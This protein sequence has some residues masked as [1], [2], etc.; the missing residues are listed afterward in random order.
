MSSILDQLHQDHINHSKLLDL[1]DSD[2]RSMQDAGTT[3][4]NEML[5]IMEYMTKYPDR[6]H[7]PCEEIIFDRLKNKGDNEAAVIRRLCD[8]HERLSA[9][10]HELVDNLKEVTKGGI[11]RKDRLNKLACEY[12]ELMRSHMDI[13]EAEIFPALKERI[14]ADEWAEINSELEQAKDPVFGEVVAAQFEGLYRRIL[15]I[16]GD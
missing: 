8:E 4:F 7:H 13:E 11:V 5:Q 6:F 9:L 12:L 16:K 10:G 14:T 15:D 1:L 3:D 2:I